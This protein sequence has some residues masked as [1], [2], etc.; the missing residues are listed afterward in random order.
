MDGE[1]DRRRL[2][3]RSVGYD[4][5]C[6]LSWCAFRAVVGVIARQAIVRRN[7]IPDMVVVV[8]K[9]LLRR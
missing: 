8:N 4:G 2:T 5:F 7:G 6:F 9:P 3:C 1:R